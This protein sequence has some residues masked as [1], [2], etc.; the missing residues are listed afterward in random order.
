MSYRATYKN[1]RLSKVEKE[2]GSTSRTDL[3]IYY[4]TSQD[5]EVVTKEERDLNGDGIPDL[6]SYFENGRLVRR[7]VSAIGLESLSKQEQLPVPTAKLGPLA[8]PGS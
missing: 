8:S 5:G 3:W 2:T 6:W 4:D 1:G 7:D